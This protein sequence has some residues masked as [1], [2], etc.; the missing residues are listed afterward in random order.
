MFLVPA[1][2]V[3]GIYLLL[4]KPKS[5]RLFL[6]ALAAFIVFLLAD[7]V[8]DGRSIPGHVFRWLKGEDGH[9]QTLHDLADDAKKSVDPVALQSWAMTIIQQ[10][11]QADS[12]YN[13]P[14]DQVP[15]DIRNFEGKG[16]PLHQ[17]SMRDGA[18][19]LQWGGGFGWWGLCV[20]PPTFKIAPDPSPGAYYN[21]YLEW[22]PGIYCWVE[23]Q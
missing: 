5:R 9:E 16:W 4:K 2:I 18:V 22:K 12:S 6:A 17:A 14:R 13:I 19:W 15:S 21:E 7:A 1:S 10:H 23:I 3:G 8:F 20:G 11:P